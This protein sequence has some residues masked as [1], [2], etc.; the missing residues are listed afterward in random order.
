MDYA[1]QIALA[2]AW[3]KELESPRRTLSSW[4][5]GFLESISER[6]DDGHL[7]SEK[8]MNVLK[9]IYEEKTA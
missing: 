8:Q 2:R 9:R 1:E 5:L 7:L 4:E 6:L 3:V